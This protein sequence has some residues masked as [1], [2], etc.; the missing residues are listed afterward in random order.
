MFAIPVAAAAPPAPAAPTIAEVESSAPADAWRPVAPEN[1][2]LVDTAKG[3]L[4]IELAPGFAPAHVAAIRKLVRD[5]GF[6]GGAVVRVQ[7]NYVVQFA[8]KTAVATANAP[9]VPATAPT[10]PAEYERLRAQ[11]PFTPLP[12][13]D[14]YAPQAG[15]SDGWPVARDA[16]AAWLVHCY[17]MVGAGRDLP[18]ST[19]DGSELYAVIGHAPR[20]LD[21]N[22]AVVG[23]VIDGIAPFA[24]LPRGT[25]AL[26]F[27]KTDAEKLPITGARLAS[28][29]PPGQRPSYEVMRTDTP[30]FAALIA[31]RAN[32]REPF[33]LR[34][35][36]GVDV[37]NVRIPVRLMAKH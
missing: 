30:S 1:L 18:P 15:F 23:R 14:A 19:G 27:Y 5:G 13:P 12:F 34:P 9:G 33:F 21:R 32:R 2:M 4:T 6:T 10:L 24:A 36:G 8:A 16:D 25:E 37:C 26:G 29:V 7:D 35:A 22:M 31:A 17:G 20:H 11:V 3:T 28:N